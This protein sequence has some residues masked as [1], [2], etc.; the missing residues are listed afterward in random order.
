M[1][2]IEPP[3]RLT[4][5]GALLRRA[6]FT[7]AEVSTQTKVSVPTLVGL[8]RGYPGVRR[9]ARILLA[10]R[11][12]VERLFNVRLDNSGEGLLLG[13]THSPARIE[14]AVD[15]FLSRYGPKK[16]KAAR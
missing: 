13:P 15:D 7:H 2:T 16:A 3:E 11:E 4:I 14:L 6:N 1:T 5:F 8:A 9:Q 10:V 12:F